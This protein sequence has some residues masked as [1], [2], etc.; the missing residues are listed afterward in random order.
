MR[1]PCAPW[2][3]TVVAALI[4]RA[5]SS[6]NAAATVEAYCDGLRP[7][8]E[9]YRANDSATARHLKKIVAG[10]ACND[11]FRTLCERNA[12]LLHIVSEYE[13]MALVTDGKVIP[14]VLEMSPLKA[15]RP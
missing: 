13:H 7:A 14:L 4:G 1:Y 11:A 5:Q 15:V 3:A 8:I 12:Q 9:K 10:R 2:T 6:P